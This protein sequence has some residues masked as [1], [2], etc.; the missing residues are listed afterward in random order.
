MDTLHDINRYIS[1]IEDRTNFVHNISVEHRSNNPR[2]DYLFCNA[3]QGKHIPAKPK[4]ISD[5][6]DKMLDELEAKLAYNNIL[7]IGFAETA[8]SLGS[9]IAD[10][11]SG[12]KYHLQTTRE[13]ALLSSL[14]NNNQLI[15]FSEEHSH[16]TQQLL[17]GNMAD[18]DKAG[19][20]DYVLF[21]EDEISTGKTIL[22]FIN[23]FKSIRD[24]IRYGVVSVCNWQSDKDRQTYK[25]NNIDTFALIRGK[26]KD[27]NAN[28][29]IDVSSIRREN[30]W[31]PDFGAVF[32]D[33]DIK[34]LVYDTGK[35]I[36]TTERCGRRVISSRYNYYYEDMLK[37]RKEVSGFIGNSSNVLVLGTEEFMYI[38]YLFARELSKQVSNVY[39]HATT[40]SSIDTTDA[41]LKSK[42]WLHS[43]YEENRQ[44]YVYNLKKYDKVIILSDSIAE[45]NVQDAFI[46]DITASL[47]VSGN[48]KTDIMYINI[49]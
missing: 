30:N 3:V 39:T 49:K 37:L 17:Y 45:Q 10:N 2:R 46:R 44:T 42:F 11:L 23:E 35:N 27:V 36:F 9:Y 19:G 4:E 43:A 47:L 1:D 32:D 38:P 21:V 25:N 15:E 40:R 33:I 29:G 20:F 24:G 8:T 12:V 6:L 28:M 48:N 41:A 14:G 5:M 31:G 18:I 13:Q 34:R 16:A 7:V 22:N 26:I